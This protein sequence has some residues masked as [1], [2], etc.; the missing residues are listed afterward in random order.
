MG[1]ARNLFAVTGAGF[2]LLGPGGELRYVGATD[3]AARALEAVQEELSEG[4]CVDSFVLGEPVATAD[5]RADD[6]WPTLAARLDGVPVRAVLGIPTMLAG[7]PVGSLNVFRD[8]PYG[9]DDSDRKALA[10]LNGVLEG[11]LGRGVA[12]RRDELIVGQ[13]QTALDRRVVIERA[14]GALMERHRLSAVSAFTALRRAAREERVAVAQ[15]A[16]EILEGA[17]VPLDAHGG[18]SL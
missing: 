18:R 17:D 1:A 15:I 9:W 4:P 6:R 8:E 13:L 14:V 12:A 3:E 10:S 11:L 5:L 7:Q 2:M 16:V